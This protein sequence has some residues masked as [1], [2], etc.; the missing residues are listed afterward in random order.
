MTIWILAFVLVGSGVGMGLRQGAIRASFSLVG[1]LLG[2][3]FATLLSKPIKLLLPHLG[4]HD[5]T[6]LWSLGPVIAFLIVLTLFKMAGHMV[7]RKVDVYYKHYTGDLQQSL[8]KRLN[9][10]VGACVG[11]LN[12]TAYLLLVVFY[13]FNF[14]YWTTQTAPSDAEARTTRLINRLGEDLQSTGFAK[15]GRSL[16]TMPDNFYK[17]A[18]LAGLLAQ[19]PQLSDRLGRYPAF[20]SLAERPDVQALTQ[21]SAFTNDWSSHAPMGQ[22]LNEP[23]VKATLQNHELITTVWGSV[24]TNL[25]DLTAYLKTGS[26]TKYDPEKILGRWDLNVNVTLGMLRQARPNIPS[27]EM[28][29]IRAIWSAAYAHTTLVASS[30]KQAFLKDLP[31]FKP[32]EPAT[33]WTGTWDNDDTN[34]VLMLSLN[35]TQKSL[36]AQTSGARLTLKGDRNTLVFDHE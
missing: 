2:A 28:R 8:W 14:S 13:I 29:T 30:D 7:H 3:L 10:R 12:G 21:D 33:T 32:G 17:T 25:D 31:T 15:V 5:L 27:K 22:M 6:A 16:V 9:S 19:N 1:I 36:T 4:V 20:L 24:Q 18:D 34:Y 35:G 23:A 26:S 11:V